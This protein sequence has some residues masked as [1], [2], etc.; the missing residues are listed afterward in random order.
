LL[1]QTLAFLESSACKE[2]VEELIEEAHDRGISGVPYTVINSK[3]AIA[4]GQTAE[5]YYNVSDPSGILIQ[6][7]IACPMMT[8]CQPTFRISVPHCRI[9]IRRRS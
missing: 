4:G 6:P 7:H 3:W 1:H 9:P 8:V 5:T 2:E